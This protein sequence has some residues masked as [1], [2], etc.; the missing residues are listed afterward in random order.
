MLG[1]SGEHGWER[2]RR[3]GMLTRSSGGARCKRQLSDEGARRRAHVV[4][5]DEAERNVCDN[6]VAAK[7]AV[8]G[9]SQEVGLKRFLLRS[10]RT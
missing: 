5:V 6:G 2:N 4:A 10:G 3:H 9:I 8:K 7:A 1:G